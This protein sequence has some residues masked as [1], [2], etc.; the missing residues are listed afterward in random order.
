MK[1][2]PEFMKHLNELLDTYTQEVKSAELKP[3]AEKTYLLHGENF[4]RWCSG[5]FVTGSR[6]KEAGK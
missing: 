3:S 6:L 1:V 2:S 5:D 4:V